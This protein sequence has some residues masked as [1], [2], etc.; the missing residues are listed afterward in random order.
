MSE[1]HPDYFF[2]ASRDA[3]YLAEGT[4]PAPGTC[5][6]APSPGDYKEHCTRFS[7]PSKTTKPICR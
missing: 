5:P 3:W 6:V 1:T 7:T 2:A 4:G